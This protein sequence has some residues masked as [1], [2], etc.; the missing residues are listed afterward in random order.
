MQGEPLPQT[1]IEKYGPMIDENNRLPMVAGVSLNT[2]ISNYVAVLTM[3]KDVC[4]QLTDADLD[5]VV[6]FGHDNEKQATIRWG[7]WHIADHSRY[8]QAQI[9]QLRKWYKGC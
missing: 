6:T 5:Q 8:H 2:L 7:I 1:L 4:T 3:L 9:N